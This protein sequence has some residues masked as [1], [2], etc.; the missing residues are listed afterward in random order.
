MMSG[1]GAVH[2]ALGGDPISNPWLGACIL[3]V[4]MLTETM[5]FEEYT[6]FHIASMMPTRL[7]KRKQFPKLRDTLDNRRDSDSPEKLRLPFLRSPG[8]TLTSPLVIDALPS[9]TG[10]HTCSK[11]VSRWPGQI[12]YLEVEIYKVDNV[13]SRSREHQHEFKRETTRSYLRCK[14]GAKLLPEQQEPWTKSSKLAWQVE[15]GTFKRAF[16]RNKCLTEWQ[17]QKIQDRVQIQEEME[18]LKEVIMSLVVCDA[19]LHWE[20]VSKVHRCSS[21]LCAQYCSQDC[22]RRAWR[23]H[24]MVC[25]LLKSD[26]VARRWYEELGARRML[27]VKKH[28][29]MQVRELD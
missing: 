18:I 13:L 29:R 12:R 3:Q 24:K 4:N 22:A 26:E 6:P 21:C 15:E 11:D 28:N 8:K 9:G 25:E 14:C 5:G 27:E 2:A 23:S 19:C 16:C 10:C 20:D 7:W 17:N 1:M